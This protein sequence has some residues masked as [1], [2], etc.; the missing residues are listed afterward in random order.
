MAMNKRERVAAA[1]RGDAVDRVPISF[2]G[3]N[4]LKEW[5]AAGLA[6]AMLEPFRSYDWDYMK[7]NPRASYHV[8]DWGGELERANDPNKGPTFKRPAVTEPADFRR[9]RPLEPNQGVLGEQ[10][11]AL[12]Q[13]GAELKGEA[14]FVQTIF[15]P[16]SIAKYLVGNRPEPI[17]TAIADD[18]GA[19]RR[20]L[21]VIVETFAIYA[22]ACIEAGA[23]GIFFATTGWASK[24]ALPEDDYRRWGRDYDLAVLE[25]FA[26]RGSFNI[27]HNCGDGIYFDL[28]TDYPVHAISWAAT[29]PGNPSLA[30]ALQR[31][32]KAVM[33]GVSEKT[34]LVDGTPE[35]VAAEVRAAI[36]E[37]GGRR[38]LVAP[39]CSIAPRAP[40]ENLIAAARAAR[41]AAD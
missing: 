11:E 27:L 36:D 25:A 33:G 17:R 7:V 4:Y 34:T 5:S 18:P 30:E 29:L 21:D 16:L 6:D 3:H 23:D 38:V 13:I 26:N 15:T 39:G 10:L 1:L 41:P 35:E 22:Q 9:L 19:L 31:T 40:A 28:L 12:R 20:V 24:D 32:S 8:E 2:W 14:P 37:T